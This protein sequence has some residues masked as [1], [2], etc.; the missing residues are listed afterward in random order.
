LNVSQESAADALFYNINL[1][2]RKIKITAT[3]ATEGS[4]S[5]ETSLYDPASSISLNTNNVKNLL[6]NIQADLP[7]VADYREVSISNLKIRYKW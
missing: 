4:V 1:N 2:N 3:S 6:I 5:T 7:A